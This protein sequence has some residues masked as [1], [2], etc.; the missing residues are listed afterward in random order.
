MSS[1]S[2]Q[3]TKVRRIT[4]HCRD[5]RLAVLKPRKD[6]G[7]TT[8]KFQSLFGTMAVFP[9]FS[10]HRYSESQE[11]LLSVASSYLYVFVL[12]IGQLADEECIRLY[13]LPRFFRFQHLPRGRLSAAASNKRHVY[14]SKIPPLRREAFV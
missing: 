3:P 9:Q 2:T 10:C 6:R 14:G 8:R 11:C 4:D 1:P 5:D 7:V 12:E 13:Q